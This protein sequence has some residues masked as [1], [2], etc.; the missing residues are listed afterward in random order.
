MEEGLSPTMS[1]YEDDCRQIHGQWGQLNQLNQVLVGRS[2]HERLRIQETYLAMYGED[3]TEKLHQEAVT[4]Q[5]NEVNKFP[6]LVLVIF[7]FIC[8]SF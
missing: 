3:L 2:L 7:K 8:P 5:D 1:T 4:N 6:P